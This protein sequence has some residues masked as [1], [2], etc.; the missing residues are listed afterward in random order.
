MCSSNRPDIRLRRLPAYQSLISW[1]N[2]TVVQARVAVKRRVFN[3]RHQFGYINHHVPV[4]EVGVH[5]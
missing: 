4:E 3:Q 5:L 1:T 2:R